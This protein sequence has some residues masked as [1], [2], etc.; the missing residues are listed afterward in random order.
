MKLQDFDNDED[1]VIQDKLKRKTWNEIRTNDSWAIFKI[2][3]EFVNGY[4]NMARIGPCVSIFGS[5]RTKPEDKY[6]LLAEKIAYKISKAGYGVIT[7]GGPGIMEASNKGAQLGGGTSV[8]LNITLPFEQH[9]NPYIDGDKNLNF[10]YFFV[11]KVMFVK[12]SQGFVV[13][14]GGFGTMDELFEALTL[15]QTKKIGKFPIILVGTAFWSG[16]I[17]W[18]RTILVEK[19]QTVHLED[20]DLYK[21]VDTEDEVVDVL[22]KFYKKYNLTPNF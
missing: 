4:E 18:I 8:G 16:L 20:L 15:I 22:D 14:P 11:R 12:Y 2:M 3:S 17:D 21:I 10:D 19:E 5:A 1:K 13:M 9:F 6:Y 7:G